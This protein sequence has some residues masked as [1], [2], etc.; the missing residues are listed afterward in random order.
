M[1]ADLERVDLLGPLD[2]RNVAGLQDLV[3]R[4]G[5]EVERIDHVVG[6]ERLTIVEDHA[7]AQVEL[8]REVVDPAP[9]RGQAGLVFERVGIAFDQLIPDH[10][11]GENPFAAGVV[12]SVRDI[13]RLI[14]RDIE[15]VVLLA[16]Q[17]RGGE[18]RRAHNGQ[19]AQIGDRSAHGCLS[20]VRP[21][22]GA[23]ASP[24]PHRDLDDLRAFSGK[25]PLPGPDRERPGLPGPAGRALTPVRARG[26]SRPRKTYPR[27]DRL[28]ADARG[29]R[30]CITRKLYHKKHF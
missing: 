18:Q 16:G 22:H 7:A 25:S 10:A 3:G 5:H 20:R 2:P 6:I 14:P 30:N 1:D 11:G 29:R 19:R 15:R 26:A 12:I 27:I 28:E 17:R 13:E 9:R 24:M 4:I 21:A 8:E 23:A